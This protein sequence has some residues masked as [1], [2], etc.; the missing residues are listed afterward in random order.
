M[1]KS[2]SLFPVQDDSLVSGSERDYC[3]LI[4]ILSVLAQQ[5]KQSVQKPVLGFQGNEASVK[6]YP[7][8]LFLQEGKHLCVRET[9]SRL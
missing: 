8:Q 2:S 7:G 9:R 3:L 4:P 1:D 6:A 5:N